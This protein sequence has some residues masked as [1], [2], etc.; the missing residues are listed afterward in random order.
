[1]ARYPDRPDI[2]PNPIP[3]NFFFAISKNIFFSRYGILYLGNQ[4]ACFTSHV[5]GLVSLVI[6]LKGTLLL[7]AVV[8]VVLTIAFLC[9]GKIYN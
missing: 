3:N 9:I 2:Q 4:F 5:P 7:L 8:D 1:M 6:P